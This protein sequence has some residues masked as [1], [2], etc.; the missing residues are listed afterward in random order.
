MSA[1]FSTSLTLVVLFKL[2]DAG[3]FQS[4][5]PGYWLHFVKVLVTSS[6]PF[7]VCQNWFL[8]LPQKEATRPVKA[9][10]SSNKL[11]FLCPTAV[12]L[13]LVPWI[14]QPTTPPHQEKFLQF[15]Q[16]KNTVEYH[17]RHPRYIA[18][19]LMP[20]LYMVILLKGPLHCYRPHSQSSLQWYCKHYHV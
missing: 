16:L 8:P 20:C 1:C 4:T 18:V 13:A 2:F 14:K 19:C 5:V 15:P 12:H 10:K 17:P 6:N 3:Y 7:I 11:V 9:R